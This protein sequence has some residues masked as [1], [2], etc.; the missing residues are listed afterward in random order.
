MDDTSDTRVGVDVGG[1]FT[2]LVVVEDGRV[3][4]RK[5]PSTPSAPEQGVFDALDAAEAG[6][7]TFFGHGTTVATNAVLEG[8]WADTALVTTEG[9]RDVLEIGRQDRPDLYDA[10]TAKPEPIVPRD[11]R[12]AVTE[13]VSHRGEVETP[14]TEE[15]V[16]AAVAAVPAEVDSVAVCLLF[17]FENPAHERRLAEAFEREGY[18]V[19]TSH[20]VL[21]EIREFERTAT[22]ALNAA[23]APV[24][25][26]YLDALADGVAQRGLPSARIMA[27]SGGL[28]AAPAAAARPVETLLS[29]PAAGVQGAAYVGEAAGVENLVTMD[30]GG[31]SCDVSLVRDGEP[32]VTS[33]AT[34]GDYPASVP[35]VDVHT[36][37]AGGGSVAWVDEGG[38][39]R[40]GPRSAGASPGPV[41][42]GRGGERP[43]VTDAHVVLGRID[44]ADFVDEPASEAT[45]R[46]AFDSA[47][48][49]P[50][51]LTVEEAAQGVVDVADANME[52]AL[53]VV[54]VERGHDPREFGLVAY[55][56]AG[57]LHA[58]RLGER[59]G[60]DRVLVPAAAGVLSALGLLCGDVTY[61]FGRTM[62]RRWEAVDPGDV[63]D[64][65][66]EFRSAGE[67][68]LADA[69]VPSDR[70]RFD[71][72]VDVRYRGQSFTLTVD[73]PDGD[74]TEAALATVRD[75]FH[76]RHR[77]RY[78]HAAPGEPLE[79]VAVRADARGVVDPPAL[80]SDRPVATDTPDPTRSRD[81][82]FEGT[83]RET[84]VYDREA[85]APGH[86]FDGP[87]L[88]T[89]GETT[90]VLPPDHRATVDRAGNV[91]VTTGGRDD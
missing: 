3:T 70:R 30:M 4:V 42:Y 52:R 48:A 72:R 49:D 58:A 44:P 19:S 18:D 67:A 32:V 51:G 25:R 57:P 82:T 47:V 80:E 7:A 75:R 26:G 45:V 66:A 23:L 64:V 81:V 29:G 90:L 91:V 74:V 77:E 21:P 63:A 83:V 53:R 46:A 11:R 15:A 78:G 59:L 38:A 13:R 76:E 22:T 6:G 69:G 41:C 43:T 28:V 54:S 37:G 14:L 60:V 31:T 71:R 50:L 87:A 33:E 85:L 17:A 9:F 16:D 34:V 73:L 27:S 84:A 61:G 5:T 56:G 39:L 20:E 89:G 35:T 88:V 12:L 10:T 55:G 2:D 8:T 86:E 36:V 68:K 62:V 79:L 1:T 65:L 24:M 40:V